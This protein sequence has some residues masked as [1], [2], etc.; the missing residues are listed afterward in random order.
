[1]KQDI[2]AEAIKAAPPVAVAGAVK[3][4]GM[5]LNEWVLALTV[6]YLLLQMGWLLFKFW[7]AATKKDW[8][9]E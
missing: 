1:M 7:K 6:A 2:S 4:L 3:V 8:N 5:S 9:P